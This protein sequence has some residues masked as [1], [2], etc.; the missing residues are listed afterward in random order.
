MGAVFTAG[1]SRSGGTEAT[2]LQLIHLLMSHGLVI[3]GLPWDNTMRSS[4][5]YYGA[6][7]HGKITDEDEE[8]A[9]KLGA[10]VAEV[11]AK[12]SH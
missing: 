4:G 12:L 8:Q 3:V 1:Y 6:S 10:R 5:S 9:R 2:L 11:A 7:V